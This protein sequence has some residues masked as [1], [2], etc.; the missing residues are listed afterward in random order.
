MEVVRSLVLTDPC[1]FG[2]FREKW[3]SVATFQGSLWG[4]KK[5]RFRKKPTLSQHCWTENYKVCIG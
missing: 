4:F 3:K 2:C 1:A 5:K